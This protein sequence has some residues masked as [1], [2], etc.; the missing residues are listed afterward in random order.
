MY[1][2]YAKWNLL[3]RQSYYFQNNTPHSLFLENTEK[4]KSTCCSLVKIFLKMTKIHDRHPAYHA[5]LDQI[6]S[7]PLLKTPRKLY[8]MR[9]VRDLRKI[10]N[11]IWW[12]EVETRFLFKNGKPA[13][14]IDGQKTNHVLFEFV[15][16]QY[17]TL[18]PTFESS[19][20]MIEIDTWL[21]R[22]HEELCAQ[23]EIIKEAK[24][25][26]C[27]K[28][29]LREAPARVTAKELEADF[30]N[31]IH[32]AVMEYIQDHS[33]QEMYDFLLTQWTNPDYGLDKTSPERIRYLLDIQE[34]MPSDILK[35]TQTT[36]Q[37]L[38]VSSQVSDHPLSTTIR[39]YAQLCNYITVHHRLIPWRNA[40]WTGQRW[41]Q[42]WKVVEWRSTHGMW[43]SWGN[44]PRFTQIEYWKY[45]RKNYF[46]YD[47]IDGYTIGDMNNFQMSHRPMSLKFWV[48]KAWT[49]LS[50]T[51]F[52]SADSHRNPLIVQRKIDNMLLDFVKSPYA[53]LPMGIYNKVDIP[54]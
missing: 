28:F 40:Q 14:Y 23:L 27:K 24:G 53:Q 50:R 19:A 52:R 47:K 10:L 43:I 49:I 29:W 26:I 11:L 35:Y 25:A 13:S 48:D 39:L 22:S 32:P 46:P 2:V 3:I 21:C 38:T 33:P 9:N 44:D 34:K 51:E 8:P 5:K 20:H 4:R 17:P 1:I 18:H 7:S 31:P 41:A 15:T 6:A 36:S 30:V 12:S 37:Q 16:E 54:N 42:F 45:I